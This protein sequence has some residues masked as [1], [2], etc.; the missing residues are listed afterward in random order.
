MSAC[1]LLSGPEDEAVNKNQVHC[2]HET[3]ILVGR[4]D[5]KPSAR[6]SL[7]AQWLRI[8]LPTQGTQ[9]STSG[10]GRSHMLWRNQTVAA[11]VQLFSPVRLFATLWTVAHQASLSFTISQSLL[12]LMSIESV[13]PSNHLSL[14]HPLLL[15]PSVFPSI[16]VFS[17]KSA[18]RI[19]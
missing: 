17:S 16:R 7:V 15:L 3:S 5:N 9:G 10:L 13:M 18:L 2:S 14:C 11:V 4:T 6:T 12:K 1:L 8:C 19:R